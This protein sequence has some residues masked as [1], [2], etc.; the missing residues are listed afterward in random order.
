M[1]GNG[2]GVY[3]SVFGPTRFQHTICVFTETLTC[4]FR[5]VQGNLPELLATTLTTSSSDPWAHHPTSNTLYALCTPTPVPPPQ[6]TTSSTSHNFSHPPGQQRYD[7]RH[8]D[9]QARPA[10]QACA[11]RRCSARARP[12]R[13]QEEEIG[14]GTTFMRTTVYHNPY[15]CHSKSRSIPRSCNELRIVKIVCN[16]SHIRILEGTAINTHAAL[17][18]RQ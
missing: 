15:L 4:K 17:D 2:S 6:F 1:L 10:Q 18:T 14:A 7:C 3:T 9:S 12:R 16:C 5:V 8:L 11:T 13:G